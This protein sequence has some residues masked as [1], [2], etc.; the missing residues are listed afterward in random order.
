MPLLD[1]NSD[2]SSAEDDDANAESTEIVASVQKRHLHSSSNADESRV[3]ADEMLALHASDHPATASRTAASSA[4]PPSPLCGSPAVSSSRRMQGGGRK[5]ATVCTMLTHSL[6]MGWS[7]LATHL[8]SLECKH[9]VCNEVPDGIQSAAYWV[10]DDCHTG[11]TANRLPRLIAVWTSADVT[12][13]ARE[14]SLMR[15]WARAQSVASEWVPGCTLTIVVAGC[16]TAGLQHVLGAA[17]LELGLSARRVLNEKELAVLLA[18]YATALRN[19]ERAPT[20]CE[21]FLGGLTSADMLDNTAVPRT[22]AQSWVGALKQLL[23]ESAAVAV[24]AAYPSF[25]L[26]YADLAAN[27]AVAEARLQDLKVGAKRLGPARS[28]RLRRVFMT[29]DGQQALSDAY[30]L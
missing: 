10:S 7:T 4:V 28:R 5:G 25:R 23:P 14:G 26:L 8:T 11:L 19:A 17:Q 12:R 21:G 18:S 9:E 13:M 3:A 29:L 2:S 15:E 22:A 24:H 20:V 16:A 27:P 6:N 30:V 1:L